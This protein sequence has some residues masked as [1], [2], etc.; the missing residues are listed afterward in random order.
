MTK[1][2]FQSFMNARKIIRSLKLKSSNEWKEY[3]KSGHRPNDIPHKPQEVYKNKGWSSWGDF[4]GT[5]IIASYKI[6]YLSF[7]S[8]RKYARTLKLKNTT[9]WNKYAKSGKLPKNIPARPNQTYKNK[10]WTTIPD[11]LGTKNLS[12]KTRVYISY[13]E[14]RKFVQKNKITTQIEWGVYW[15]KHT[16]PDNIPYKPRDGYKNKGWNGWGDFLGTY[17]VAN[18][19]ISFWP[20]EK[21]M[22]YVKSQNFKNQ[23]EFRRS[24]K[25]NKLPLEIPKSPMTVYQD[26]GWTSWGDFLG[27]GFVD[28]KIK[29][30]NYLSLDKAKLEARLLAKIYN[31]KSHDDW[32]KA[33]QEGKIP[34]YLP[35]NPW[36]VYPKRT[37]K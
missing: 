27:N 28:N 31:L 13:N 21:S 8:A 30:Q 35:R 3:C 11:W 10:G 34:K 16:K 4:L 24:A 22:K 25:D 9:A 6:Q 29:S 32:I 7:T 1:I 17:R 33:H 12:N 19:N 5:G 23:T 18:Q 36:Q 14:C 2:I 37:K 26:K 20:Y 15:K